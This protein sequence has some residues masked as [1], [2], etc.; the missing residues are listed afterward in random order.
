MCVF[1]QLGVF[2]MENAKI[3]VLYGQAESLRQIESNQKNE[4]APDERYGQCC[5]DIVQYVSKVQP[6]GIEKRFRKDAS[7]RRPRYSLSIVSPHHT[8]TNAIR[9]DGFRKRN[10][11][12][13]TY[14]A[15]CIQVLV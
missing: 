12:S 1:Q 8:D 5:T 13:N 4:L 14:M 15:Q 9:T 2:R 11:P 7:H 6:R 3:H 10:V